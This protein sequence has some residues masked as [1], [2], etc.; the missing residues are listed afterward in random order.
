MPISDFYENKIGGPNRRVKIDEIMLNFEIKSYRGRAPQNRMDSL[1]KVEC[2][3]NITLVF[4]T[5]ITNKKNTI[6][7]P[8]IVRQDDANTKIWTNEHGA[9]N[10]LGSLGFEHQT[11]VTYTSLLQAKESIP[12][13][14]NPLILH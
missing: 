12:N 9:Y 4:A 1:C 14:L 7:I 11:V 10:N 8:I 3:P 13:L 2:N 6:I 5:I